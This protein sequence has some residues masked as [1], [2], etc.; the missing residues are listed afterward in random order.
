MTE[1]IISPTTIYLISMLNT[2]NGFLILLIGIFCFLGYKYF[3]TANI[4]EEGS[5][6]YLE[7]QSNSRKM[8]IVVITLMILFIILPSKKTAFTMF[9]ASKITTQTVNMGKGEIKSTVDYIF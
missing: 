7:N 9:V 1:P 5:K 3:E 4:Y 6:Y 8:L 2:I